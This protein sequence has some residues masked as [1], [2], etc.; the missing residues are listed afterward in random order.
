M[1][2]KNDHI[3][4]WIK[5]AEDD[6]DAVLQLQKSNKNLQA[7]FFAHLVLEKLCKAHWGKDNDI[8]IPPRTHI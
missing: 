8:N 6:W 4:Y 1:M 5:S 7:L 3:D 2:S